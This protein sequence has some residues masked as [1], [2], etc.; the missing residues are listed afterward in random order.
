[1]I[2]ANISTVKN[3]FSSYL[4]QV[5]G[6]EQVIISDRSH[7]IAMLVPYQGTAGRGQWAA[8][9]ASLARSGNLALAKTRPAQRP[10]VP[11][12]AGPGVG[13]VDSLVQERREGR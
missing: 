3:R 1:M 7:P 2:Q 11:V 6:G 10:I 4:D 5:K 9:V 8:R 13:A 12:E